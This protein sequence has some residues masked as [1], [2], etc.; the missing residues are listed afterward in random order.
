VKRR[1]K[2]P[3]VDVEVL[4]AVPDADDV[5]HSA[6][7]RES[8]ETPP[9]RD[10]VREPDERR[11]QERPAWPAPV[12]MPDA[13]GATETSV[14]DLCEITFWRGY[15]TGAFYARLVA[16]SDP[17]TAVARSPS[18]HHRGADLPERAG[19]ALSAYEALRHALERAGWEHVRTGP[20][21]FTDV[22]SRSA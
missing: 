8:L 18:F 4:S 22:F 19:E 21:W 1:E 2:I 10:D 13:T 7:N 6:A 14:D 17:L 20:I 16:D 5:G 12:P 15:V 11:F 3:E 9:P